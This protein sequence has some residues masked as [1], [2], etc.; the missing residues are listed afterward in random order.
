MGFAGCVLSEWAR[1]SSYH[2]IH[3]HFK[4]TFLDA[5]AEDRLYSLCF[6]FSMHYYRHTPHALVLTSVDPLPR[7]HYCKLI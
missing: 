4:L 5:D 1:V 3:Q 2:T 6:P 7:M